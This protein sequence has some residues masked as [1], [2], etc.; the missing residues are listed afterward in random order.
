M[1]ANRAV[2]VFRSPSVRLRLFQRLL[3]SPNTLGKMLG[4][5][6]CRGLGMRG[7]GLIDGFSRLGRRLQRVGTLATESKVGRVGERTVRADQWQQSRTLAAEFHSWWIFKLHVGQEIED[8]A[9]PRVPRVTGC[10]ITL[11]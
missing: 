6:A 4:R 7:E 9:I 10:R 11:R 1:S 5:I 3:F 8:V 2:I